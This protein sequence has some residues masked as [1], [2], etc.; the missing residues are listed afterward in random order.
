MCST[1]NEC[2]SRKSKLNLSK[3]P[4]VIVGNHVYLVTELVLFGRPDQCGE[5][6][7]NFLSNKFYTLF[8]AT[9][10]PHNLCSSNLVR[11]LI[12]PRCP[13]GMNMD[14]ICR[15]VVVDHI[16]YVPDQIVASI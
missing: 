2:I 16:P 11:T 12:V 9:H 6:R 7:L 13:F 8:N 5:S 14:S 4:G 15:V 1:L 3:S 10:Q